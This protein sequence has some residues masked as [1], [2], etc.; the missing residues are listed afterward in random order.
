MKSSL[1]IGLLRKAERKE[2]QGR[3]RERSGSWKEREE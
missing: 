2:E 3:R 1:I